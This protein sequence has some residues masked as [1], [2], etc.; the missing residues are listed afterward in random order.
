MARYLSLAI[1]LILK[2]IIIKTKAYSKTGDTMD[3]YCKMIV[4]NKKEIDIDNLV[5]V[6]SFNSNEFILITSIGQIIIKGNN[7][8]MSNINTT[9]NKITIT[10][11]I[12]NI[13]FGEANGKIKKH[14]EPFIK[15]LF[16]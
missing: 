9:T 15:K 10:G 13:H 7:L 8:E 2:V 14:D 1:F 11:D 3:N 12:V 5:K 4:L 6:T 16:K